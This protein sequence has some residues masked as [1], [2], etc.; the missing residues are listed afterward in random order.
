MIAI[1]TADRDL[2]GKILLQKLALIDRTT[3]L[4]KNQIQELC[5]RQKSQN[6]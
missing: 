6:F 5:L 1:D 4:A 3:E 2:V